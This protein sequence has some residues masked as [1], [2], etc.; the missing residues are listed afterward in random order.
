MYRIPNVAV[1]GD[2]APPRRLT[3]PCQSRKF[4]A[5][6]ADPRAKPSPTAPPQRRSATTVPS[7]ARIPIMRYVRSANGSSSTLATRLHEANHLYQTADAAKDE[8]DKPEEG[9]T[10]P[11]VK[12]PADQVADE[13]TCRKRNRKL[14]ILG[15]LHHE[16]AFV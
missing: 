4:R 13:R 8:E 12:K 14:R 3:V 9:R 16:T 10:Q 1:T 2:F 11:L 7:R 6:N 15:V 5:E